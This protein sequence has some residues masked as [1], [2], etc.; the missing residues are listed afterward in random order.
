MTTIPY[1]LVMVPPLPAETHSWPERLGLA[2]PGI[3]V[4]CPE[5]PED[6][7]A[8][9]VDADAA[10]GTLT[11]ELLDVAQQLCWL[12]APQAGPP[13]GFY[14]PALVRH[15]VEV[16]N[17]RDTYT[18][19][20]AAHTMALVLALARQL[21]RYVREQT[22]ATWAPDWSDGAVVPL[23]EARAL[24]VGTGAIGAETGR[25]LAA[26]GT[27]VEGID[28]RVIA[29]PPGFVRVL[30]PDALDR[31]LP[32]A[33]IVILTVPHTPHTEGL[34]DARRLAAMKDGA[35]LV[36]VGRGPT[37]RLDDVVAALDTGRLRGAA[38]DVLERE[39]LPPEHPLWRHPRALITPHVAGVGPHAAE[40]RFEVLAENAQRFADGR[41]LI[42]VVDKSLWF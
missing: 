33:D 7:R 16:T 19:H 15:P 37:V 41:P 38:L 22:A 23:A 18:D 9:L 1:T 32:L 34:M 11:P 10:Y 2:V 17:M 4:L 35:C 28:A 21:P 8:A 30:P 31:A 39:P 13:P 20:V 3:K 36:N 42:N 29:A 26:F 25:L 27:Q 40:R 14:H 5:T 24:I 6:V 12:Q